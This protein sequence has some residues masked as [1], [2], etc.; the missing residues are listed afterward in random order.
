M[1]QQLHVSVNVVYP[2]INSFKLEILYF[3]IFYFIFNLQDIGS[4]QCRWHVQ[5]KTVVQCQRG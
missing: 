4:S 5:T 2:I 1:W 3:F